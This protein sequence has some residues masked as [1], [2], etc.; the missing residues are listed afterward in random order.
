MKR[1]STH[2]VSL[3]LALVTLTLAPGSVSRVHA[4][5]AQ[6]PPPRG[7]EAG[8]WV[9]APILGIGYT[10]D[11]NIFRLDEEEE[12]EQIGE[13]VAALTA[14]LPF[15]KSML[16]LGYS[17]EYYDYA[18]NNFTRT[19]AQ[20]F[21]LD[22]DVRL[23]GGGRIRVRDDYTRGFSDVQQFDE[24]GERVFDGKPYD[25]NDFEVTFSRAVPY[26]PGYLLRIR[27]RDFSFV[28]GAEVAF[29]DYKGWDASGEYRQPIPGSRWLTLFGNSRR[30]DHSEAGSSGD[31]FRKEAA[32]D[33][34]IGIRGLAGGDDPYFIK[35]GWGRFEYQD[36]VG[37]VTEPEPFRGVVGAFQYR[38]RISHAMDMVFSGSRRPLPSNFDTYYLVNEM[39]VDLQRTWQQFSIMGVKAL[40]SANRYGDI[41]TLRDGTPLTTCSDFIRKDDRYRV[42][43]YGQWWVNDLLGVSIA[44]A[45]QGRNSNCAI[46][47]YEANVLSANIEFGWF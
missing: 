16:K 47:E 27:S 45:H 2:P 38:L 5:S 46:S 30:L 12:D 13:A 33:L 15:R 31:P 24:G 17:A 3:L 14:Y 11:D 6:D 4:Q 29:F 9:L 8:P 18:N 34:Q 42:E 39:Q 10:N 35:L 7:L 1:I 23:A 44:A 20:D 19:V 21:S 36:V 22:L 32:D 41:L 26:H 28:E 25:L 43:A 40:Y 37:A